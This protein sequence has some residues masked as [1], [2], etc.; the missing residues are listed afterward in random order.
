M[1]SPDL[2]LD[3]IASVREKLAVQPVP[4]LSFAVA[5]ADALVFEK[6]A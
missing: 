4:H 3:M 5:D 2:S 1:R 6:A